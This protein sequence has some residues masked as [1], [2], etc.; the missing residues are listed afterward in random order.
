MQ[1]KFDMTTRHKANLGCLQAT[2]AQNF[3]LPI[4]IDGLGQHVIG[5]V[6][7]YS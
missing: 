2:H 5:G 3:L 7:C 6:P 1:V 4:L